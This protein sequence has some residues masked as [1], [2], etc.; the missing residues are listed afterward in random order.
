[1]FRTIPSQ[2]AKENK[3]FIFTALRK[4]ARGSGYENAIAWLCDAG[5]IRRSHSVSVP[6]LP[7][8]A[9]ARPNAF[10][11]YA[12]DVGLLCAMGHLPESVLVERNRLFEEFKG[13]L[14]ENYVAQQ[15]ALAEGRELYYWKSDRGEAEVDFLVEH[16]GEILPL[17]VKAGVSPKSKSL[18]SYGKRFTP[19]LLSRATLLN[20][21]QDGE[22]L[23]YPLYAVCR[24]PGM[25]S[26]A[27]DR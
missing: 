27:V 20:W 12:L 26:V 13:A 18:R 2:L 8:K 25:K 24:F 9:Y 14:T 21:K 16:A 23:N 3:K 15:L 5:L 7:L 6:H 19:R 10:K 4:S 17:E 22:E 11:V 1:M